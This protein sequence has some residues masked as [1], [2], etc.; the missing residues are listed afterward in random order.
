MSSIAQHS[1]V[2]VICWVGN[3][4]FGYD[5]Y[6]LQQC[7]THNYSNTLPVIITIVTKDCPPTQLPCWRIE[8]PCI[9]ISLNFRN[10]RWECFEAVLY[11]WHLM[12][13][14]TYLWRWTLLGRADCLFGSIWQLSDYFQLSERDPSYQVSIR[15]DQSQSTVWLFLAAVGAQ[16]TQSWS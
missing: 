7:H 13:M 11:T 14:Q 8:K 3:C 16:F 1:M 12:K 4:T 6:L 15:I 10:V 9:W 5:L 2:C